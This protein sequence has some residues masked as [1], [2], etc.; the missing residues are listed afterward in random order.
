MT[1]LR[2][3][4]D[5]STPSTV[6]YGGL[7]TWASAMTR[8]DLCP[9]HPRPQAPPPLLPTLLWASTHR[10]RGLCEREAVD[11]E[12]DAGCRSP[13]G[14]CSPLRRSPAC[15]SVH[16]AE[17]RLHGAAPHLSPLFPCLKLRSSP[18]HPA[19]A[20]P[21][22]PSPGLKASPPHTIPHSPHLPA[23]LSEGNCVTSDLSLK[24]ISVL[25]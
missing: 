8:K 25:R 21:T 1:S 10:K 7:F 20:P 22:S 4:K 11:I 15:T 23:Y 9:G 18:P 6:H 19:P 13:S 5:T 2:S 16:G 24:V 3:Y 17:C 12:Q 14:S